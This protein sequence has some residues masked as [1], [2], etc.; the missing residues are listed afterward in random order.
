MESVS[1]GFKSVR[2]ISLHSLDSGDQFWI[3]IHEVQ[4]LK[5]VL[6][7]THYDFFYYVYVYINIFVCL[8]SI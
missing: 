5:M 6:D 2:T 1:L 4:G 3:L 7:L 8:Y